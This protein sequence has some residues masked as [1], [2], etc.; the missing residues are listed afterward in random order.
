MSFAEI[1]QIVAQRVS[2]AIKIIAIYEA[3]TRVAHD[4]M[5]RVE[6]QE[7]KVAKN[8]SNKRK[9][10]GD[11]GGSSSQNKGH[12]VIRAHAIGPTNKK[13]YVGKLPY[14]NRCKLHHAGPCFV[15]CSNCK[16]II[17]LNRDCKASAPATTSRPSVARKMTEVT[18]YKCGRLGHYKSD[19]PIWKCQNRVNKYWNGKT[20]GNSNVISNNVNV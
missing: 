4:L 6:R 9:W 13:V 19:C 10:E 15:Q 18:C 7:G 11:H 17:H 1:E 8:D 20:C 5:N 16:R 3:N 2:N 14:Y 12:K